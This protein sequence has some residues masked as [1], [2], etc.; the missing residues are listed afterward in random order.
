MKAYKLKIELVGSDPLIWRRLILPANVTFYRLFDTIQ[1]A[2][3]WK[4]IAA[5][6]HHL[7]EFMLPDENIRVT[8]D[9][10]ALDDQKMMKAT[11]DAIKRGKVLNP[12]NIADLKPAFKIRQSQGIKIDNYLVKYGYLDYVYDLLGDRWHHRLTLEA[13]IDDYPFGFPALLDGAG[14][15]P[16]E[17]VGGFDGY[18]RFRTAMFDPNHPDQRKML[19]LAMEQNWRPFDLAWTNEMLKMIQIHKTEWTKLGLGGGH[20]NLTGHELDK[21]C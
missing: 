5:F 13:V 12:F 14:N 17:D 20:Y 9:A 3:G 11:R 8:N 15:C 4:G 2:M 6:P 18:A 21:Y 16:P 10:D 1:S 7:F 19:Q